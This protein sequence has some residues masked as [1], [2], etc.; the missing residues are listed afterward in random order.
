MNALAVMATPRDLDALLRLLSDENW[1]VRYRSA[2]A[3]AWL[4]FLEKDDVLR[5]LERTGDR[6]GRESLER[7]IAEREARDPLWR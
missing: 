5:I 3:I 4:P 2:Q 6:Y 1:W 7:S